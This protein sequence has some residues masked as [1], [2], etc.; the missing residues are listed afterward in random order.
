MRDSNQRDLAELSVFIEGL[1]RAGPLD[2]P[3]P[4]FLVF[5]KYFLNPAMVIVG[6]TLSRGAQFD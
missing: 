4:D 1:L 3:G 2:I 5:W 6:V